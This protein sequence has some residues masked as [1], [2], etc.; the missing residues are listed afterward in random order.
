MIRTLV[1]SVVSL[2]LA[3]PL[4]ASA[5]TG[6][7]T[8]HPLSIKLK[9]VT[10]MSIT[11]GNDR[12]DNGTANQKDVFESCVASSPTK[13]QG[14]YLFMN[15]ADPTINMIAAIDTD[16]LFDTAVFVGT[17]LIDTN[18]GVGTVKNG[19]LTKVIVP[20][21]VQLNC[22][23]GLTQVDAHGILNMKFSA[24]DT[25]DACPQSGSI[26][27]TGTGTDPGPGD[28]IVNEGSSITIKN[29]SGAISSFPPIPF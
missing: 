3:T 19:V 16:P 9:T 8:A 1:I 25:S 13:T 21:E 11:K 24:L 2:A 15:C 20:V 22:N 14:V 17:V 5:G 4:V 27:F 10:Q 29:R 23:G 28:F 6:P 12:P 18:H 26:T 7:I